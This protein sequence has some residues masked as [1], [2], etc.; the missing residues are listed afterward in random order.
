M[1]SKKAWELLV[2]GWLTNNNGFV[3]MDEKHT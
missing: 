3:G 2:G 1:N